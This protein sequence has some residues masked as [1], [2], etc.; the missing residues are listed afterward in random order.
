MRRSFFMVQKNFPLN[1]AWIAGACLLG[2]SVTTLAQTAAC[3]PAG[4][5]QVSAEPHLETPQAWAADAVRNELKVIGSANQVPLRYRQ[6][7]MGAKGDT[8]REVIESRDGNVARLVERNGQPISAKEDAAE[9]ARLQDAMASPDEFLR[10]RRRDSEVRDSVIK[11]VGLMPQA[12]LYSFAPGQPQVKDAEDG[13]VVLDFHPNPVFH[14]PTMFA[15]ALTGLEGRVWIDARSH[16]VT[17]IEA[18]V[19]HPVNMGFGLLAKIYPGGTLELEQTRL[20]GD[21]WVFSQ[22]NEH[23]TARLLLVKSYP[24]NTVIH[25]WNFQTMPSLLSYQDSIRELLTMQI[26]VRSP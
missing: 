25:S 9:R 14:P 15:E 17:R 13:Q 1:L 18:R 19:L 12:M 3:A 21:H 2:A 5:A 10:H 24:E 8:T 20:D 6:R 11:M 22:V 4:Q 26:P 7:K 23:L 16:Y